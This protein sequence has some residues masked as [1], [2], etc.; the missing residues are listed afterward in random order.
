MAPVTIVQGVLGGDLLPRY[1]S[2]A[3]LL[4]EPRFG[5]YG[6]SRREGGDP[7]TP[8]T[9]FAWWCCVAR[10]GSLLT[11]RSL[12]TCRQACGHCVSRCWP[13][14]SFPSQPSRV[15]TN[16]GGGGAQDGS[17]ARAKLA[18]KQAQ[19]ATP[20]K[21]SSA[22]APYQRAADSSAH[23][24]LLLACAYRSRPPRRHPLYAPW[25][26]RSRPR[27]TLAKHCGRHARSCPRGTTTSLSVGRP[28]RHTA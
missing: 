27:V 23:L 26:W 24:L 19:R 10:A 21:A 4:A 9:L 13:L 17:S 12:N 6:K 3:L 15:R 28:R 8:F 11:I 5:V 18:R 22:R 1:L 2:V 16:S 20:A 14:P 25:A 7:S